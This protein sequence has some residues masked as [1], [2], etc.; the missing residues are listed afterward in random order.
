MTRTGSW[1][2]SFCS[3]PRERCG[4]IAVV[5]SGTRGDR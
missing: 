4:I 5:R 1:T 2:R 3:R